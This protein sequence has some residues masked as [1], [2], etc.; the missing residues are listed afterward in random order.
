MS[1]LLVIDYD[2][3]L[4]AAGF[5]SE[6]RNIIVT[7][8]PS[9]RKRTFKNVT[10]FWGRK[11][12]EIGGWLGDT[13]TKRIEKGL[14]PF[15]REEFS[16]ET[17]RESE[18]IENA[19]HTSKMMIN[20]ALE[21]TNCTE[22]IGYIGRGKSFRHDFSTLLEY[23]G[24]RDPDGK[25]LLKEEMEEYL[26]KHHNA[27]I[28]EGL[29][30]DDMCI[31]TA[32][33]EDGVVCAIDKDAL[34]CPVKVFNPNYPERG[35]IDCDVFGELS[36]KDN[37]DIFGYGRIWKYFQTINGDS[38]DNYKANCFSDIKW[39]DISSYNAL[40]DVKSDKE[41]WKVMW[42]VFR[43]LYPEKKKIVGWR[44]DEIEIDALY[45]FQECFN[46]VHMWRNKDKDYVDVHSILKRYKLI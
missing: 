28:I 32:L 29:E 39:A 36:V 14:V 6:N 11:K 12:K 45:V 15:E 38:V 8:I 4:Y 37:G 35:V 34:G 10:E 46:L 41:A 27:Q 3:I 30:A 2:W 25:P 22:Y 23:K 5:A 21:K 16:V 24:N 43:H 31:I 26:I 7:H 42:E 9:G 20:T 17:V 18:P 33:E 19:L 13:N 1:K 44:G 40:K